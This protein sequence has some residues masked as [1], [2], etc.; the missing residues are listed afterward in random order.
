[1]IFYYLRHPIV[2]IKYWWI[3][4]LPWF[5]AMHLPRKVALFA[6]VRVYS[7]LDSFSNDYNNAYNLWEKGKNK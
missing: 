6:F 1:M 5:V 4:K 2:V 7:V 3:E